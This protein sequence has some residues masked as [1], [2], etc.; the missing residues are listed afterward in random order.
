MRFPDVRLLCVAW[1]AVFWTAIPATA[2]TVTI[3][4]YNVRNFL[5]VFDDPYSNDES[6]AVKSRRDIQ[7]LAKALQRLD[8]DVVVFQEL[9]NEYVLQAMIDEFLPNAGYRYVTAQRTNSGR[10]INLGV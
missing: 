10:G 4:S 8:A 3:G 7:T 1:L 5:D 9:E 2:D 6:V